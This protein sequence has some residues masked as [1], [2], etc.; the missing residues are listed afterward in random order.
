MGAAVYAGDDRRAYHGKRSQ[1][2][3]AGKAPDERFWYVN[4]IGVPAGVCLCSRP[5]LH[6]AGHFY[7]RKSEE[8]DFMKK[9]GS[10]GEFAQYSLLNILGMLGL[11][12]YILADT[13]FV[14]RGLGADGLAALNLAIP[15]YSFLH[16]SGLMIGMGGG[17]RYS[18]YRGQRDQAAA[19]RVFS[20][21]LWLAA[22]FAVFFVLLGA[23]F[24]SDICIQDGSLRRGL[25][26]EQ[27]LFTSG[28]VVCPRFPAQQCVAL[29]CAQR[30]R[31]A[32]R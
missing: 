10:F 22:G 27:D 12:C 28:F 19:C 18:I 11:S 26:N 16:G 30:R 25:W 31:P 8:M 23:F 17:I 24:S 3:G 14:S 7:F 32:A 6:N 5:A 1:G 20:G 21:A 2:T 29:L 15:V 9:T 13:F 4:G